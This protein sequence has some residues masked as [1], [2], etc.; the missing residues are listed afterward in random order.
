MNKNAKTNLE[1]TLE[2]LEEIVLTAETVTF[3][4]PM[5]DNTPTL[6]KRF[7][8]ELTLLQKQCKAWR[9]WCKEP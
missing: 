9:V 6:K 4:G 3:Y 8:K 2:M 5:R 7:D 1:K